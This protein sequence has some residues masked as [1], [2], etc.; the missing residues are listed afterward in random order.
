[1]AY[2]HKSGLSGAYDRSVAFPQ[3][4]SVLNRAGRLG[5]A[6]ELF[7]AQQILQRKI[8]SIGNLVARDGDRVEGADIIIDPETETVT[9]T[10]GRLYINGRV[11]DAPAALLTD[12]PMV[13]AVHIGVRLVETY[14]TEL[15]E[16]ALYGLAPG[17]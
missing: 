3:W 9:L 13:G 12:V 6:A 17:A 5:Q 8:R 1:M 11:L 16:P 14:V 7:E 4:D 10:V 15:E 2:E